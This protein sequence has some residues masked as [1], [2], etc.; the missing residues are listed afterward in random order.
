MTD[1]YDLLNRAIDSQPDTPEARLAVYNHIRGLYTRR[2]QEI[3]P[4][5]P[6]AEAQEEHARLVREQAALETVI[7]R[8]EAERTGVSPS[9]E[10]LL[11]FD[12]FAASEAP[13][14]PETE[15]EQQP[16]LAQ[17]GDGG[18][19]R[20]RVAARRQP[21]E[22]SA[23]RRAIAL[24]AIAVVLAGIGVVAWWLRADVPDPETIG[25]EVVAEAPQES[26]A[27]ITDRVDGSAPED[28]P[29]QQPVELAP[30]NGSSTNTAQQASPA[31]GTSDD[32]GMLAQ[33]AFLFELDEQNP[34]QPKIG[35]GQVVWRL[36]GE[37]SPDAVLHADVTLPEAGLSFTVAI[38][39]NSDETLPA[40]HTIDVNFTNAADRPD[41]VVRDLAI[42]QLRIDREP[43]GVPLSG[44]PIPVAD[45]I[46]LIG[47][48][49]LPA[50]VE[51]NY[52]LLRERDWVDLP[53]RFTNGNLGTVTFAKGSAGRQ[54]ISDAI[55]S[56][57]R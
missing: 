18:R 5:L 21:R 14:A 42:P 7:A 43:R 9:S 10:E 47:L 28:T 37:G 1:L 12:R 29:A 57:R 4:A 36:E 40:S 51:R 30:S 49:S 3:D 24:A 19:G 52:A 45:N 35:S 8:I 54:A 23:S 56:W 2:R 39:P 55:D 32:A 48:S 33:R 22:G 17:P 31:S 44:L 6:P 53:V 38:R 16:V 27:K 25:S 41:R 46:F 34:E 11:S 15:D 20:P 50:D 13:P 26:T